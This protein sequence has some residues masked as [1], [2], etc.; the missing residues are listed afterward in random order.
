MV[1]SWD[2][3]LSS[4]GSTNKMADGGWTSRDWSSTE[5]QFRLKHTTSQSQLMIMIYYY[6]NDTCKIHIHVEVCMMHN[7]CMI[8]AWWVTFAWYVY[9]CILGIYIWVSLGLP[10]GSA[11]QGSTC[12]RANVVVTYLLIYLSR[13]G[14]LI[15]S[16]VP[17]TPQIFNWP[18]LVYSKIHCWPLLIL[19]KIEYWRGSLYPNQRGLCQ[20]FNF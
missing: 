11:G 4:C 8:H 20:L 5:P 16:L 18:P 2:R 7:I 1:T 17:S 14:G 13:V 15:L 3:K 12:A 9:K 6:D 19:P 10:V